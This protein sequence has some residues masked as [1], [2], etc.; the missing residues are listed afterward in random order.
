VLSVL[1]LAVA[2]G[3]P[4]WTG[5][6]FQ[7]NSVWPGWLAALALCFG[8]A[9]C[10][11][12]ADREQVPEEWLS[13]VFAGVACALLLLRAHLDASPVWIP[14][15]WAIT[16]AAAL[17][18]GLSTR[19]NGHRAVGVGVAVVAVGGLLL[20]LLNNEAPSGE[21]WLRAP[22]FAA[23]LALSLGVA[24]SYLCRTWAPEAEREAVGCTAA[25]VAALV[26]LTWSGVEL[27]A[28][29]LPFSWLGVTLALLWAGARMDRP[30]LRAL[31]IAAAAVLTCE[32]VGKELTLPS[33]HLLLLHPRSAAVLSALAAWIATAWV[34]HRS[35]TEPE[36]AALPALVVI[37]NLHALG[38][39]S[40]E[41]MDLGLRLGGAAWANAAAQLGLSAAWI[42]YAAAAI[43]TGFW[44]D[45][46]AVRWGGVILLLLAVAKV[47]LFDLGFLALGY[48][49]LSF[50]ILAVVLFG[51]SYLYQKSGVGK[52]KT[53]N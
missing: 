32:V 45:N 48:R 38:W 25:G 41:A 16:A 14:V 44:R 19:S 11:Q 13:P 47:Y 53:E 21:W 27:H 15:A 40:L 18:V 10:Y 36:R 6:G 20:R 3:E 42:L 35:G 12:R 4:G 30:A 33:E 26:A 1:P 39:V 23:T 37:A 46:R 8:G 9:V 2:I 50:L 24:W 7:P 17:G 22:G 52:S 28:G 43:G 34:V 31:G 49:V 51:V 5:G 29:W